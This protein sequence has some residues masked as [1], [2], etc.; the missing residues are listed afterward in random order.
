MS[1]SASSMSLHGQ[2]DALLPALAADRFDAEDADTELSLE[3]MTQGLFLGYDPATFARHLAALDDG[4]P[5]PEIFSWRLAPTLAES[6][7]GLSADER[8][9]HTVMRQLLEQ[10]RK[11]G[12]YFAAFRA[13][14]QAHPDSEYL[15]LQALAYL[16]LWDPDQADALEA[17]L[18]MLHPTWLTMRFTRA[19]QMLLLTDPNDPDPEALANFRDLMDDRYELHEHSRDPNDEEVMMFYSATA[20]YFTLTGHFFRAIYSLNLADAAGADHLQPV[21]T[22]LLLKLFE[23][24]Q[25]AQLKQFLTPL[26][27]DRERRWAESKSSS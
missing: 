9:I 16:Q 18:V 13:V 4:L 8:R 7:A 2:P 15:M 21:M 12:K 27:L 3:E 26:R 19:A 22:Q 14:C 11:S 17:S 5:L 25:M 10:K 20:A 6:V 24:K 1:F 23:T